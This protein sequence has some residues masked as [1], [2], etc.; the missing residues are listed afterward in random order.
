VR[1]LVDAQ[2]PPQLARALVEAGFAADHVEAL[3]LR[4][5]KDSVIWQH[6]IEHQAIILTKDEDFVE[7]FRRQSGGPVI[8]WLRIGNSAN[9][10]LLAWFLPVLP[11]VVRRIAAEDRL[12]EVR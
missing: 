9:G 4:H 6:A 8:V 11:A 5:A 7:R 10:P 12:I 2:L 1:F 3:G